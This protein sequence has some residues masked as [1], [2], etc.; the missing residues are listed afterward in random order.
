MKSIHQRPESVSTRAQ[1]GHLEDGLLIGAGQRS[2]IANL[3]ERKARLRSEHR[4]RAHRNFRCAA[5]GV[6]AH[7]NW[8]QGNEMFLHERIEL[9][10]GLDIYFAEPY[11]PWQRGSNE[12]T[13]GL[14]R[15]YF[16][17]GSNSDRISTN[18]FALS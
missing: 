5:E 13:N 16:P 4:Q 2:A 12:N 8:D 9:A 11:S 18:G 10:T 15:Q 3:V 14:L 6:A 7:P 1:I 17:K